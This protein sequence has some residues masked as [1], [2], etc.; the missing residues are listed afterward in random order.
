L[1]IGHGSRF[2]VSGRLRRGG[3]GPSIPVASAPPQITGQPQNA[4]AI[5]GSNATFS[6]AATSAGGTV[7]YQWRRNGAPI[8]GET[9]ST[10]I[11]TAIT[12][13]ES[14]A[15]ISVVVSDGLGSVT[16]NDAVLTVNAVAAVAPTITS[17]PKNVTARAGETATFSVVSSG[18]AP[19][20]YQWKLNGVNIPGANS[21][22][23]STPVISAL[24]PSGG[25]YSVNVSNAAGNVVSSESV[26]NIE[27]LALVSPQLRR[28]AAGFNY[29]IAILAN[30]K[31]IGWGT[32][33]GRPYLA[34]SGTSIP[35][36]VAREI[37]IAAKSVGGGLF[38]AAALGIDGL[39][40]GWGERNIQ[41]VTGG[42]L[43]SL[44]YIS[45]ITE[46]GGFPTGMVDFAVVDATNTIALR[47]DG[48]VW[49][50]P[51]SVTALSEGRFRIDPKQVLGLPIIAAIGNVSS[52]AGGRGITIA[53]D[54]TVWEI[55]IQSGGLS[56]STSVRKIAS[57]PPAKQA[58]CGEQHCLVLG[59]DGTV[60]AWGD[61]SYGALGI[62]I[63]ASTVVPLN[64]VGIS[65]IVAIAAGPRSSHAITSDG[66]VYSWG[67][68]LQSGVP[69]TGLTLK[70]ASI[71]PGLTEVVEIS[72]GDT[73]LV[74]RKDGTVFG[75]GSNFYGEIGNGT[76]GEALLPKQA[77]G[78]SLN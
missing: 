31:A 20:I 33:N 75:W 63:D 56:A 15:K 27:V 37:G 5:A 32:G 62:G 29:S 9:K 66:R 41:S 11:L 40:Y 57:L 44:K 36:T 21:A 17:Q 70:V 61:N 64:V 55:S 18:T 2:G 3:G 13:A 39:I 60:W 7:T 50:M 22:N 71:V 45:G 54:G 4:S 30:G 6:V 77:L 25:K 24:I 38:E 19:L 23:Y 34:G 74:R 42:T 16:S 1:V 48:T 67:Y 46:V 58:S 69:G 8:A 12:V 72:A 47:S 28:I 73:I 65:S 35:G 14:G 10:L 43:S 51:G 53:Q 49:Q 76:T 68:R 78:I 26:L 59:F 52:L